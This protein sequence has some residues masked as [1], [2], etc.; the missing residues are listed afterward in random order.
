MTLILYPI[1][2]NAF[3]EVLDKTDLDKKTMYL[4]MFLI[5]NVT[6][7][8][9][10]ITDSL[11]CKIMAKIWKFFYMNIMKNNHMGCSLSTALFLW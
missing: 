6:K 4:R 11:V 1:I 2:Q 9:F 3:K 5:N 8:T 10:M 7:I